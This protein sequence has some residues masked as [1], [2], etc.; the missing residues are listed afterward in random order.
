MSDIRFENLQLPRDAERLMAAPA[1]LADLARTVAAEGR[2]TESGQ[3]DITIGLQGSQLVA[4]VPWLQ[5][6]ARLPMRLGERVL[7]TLRLPGMR[8]TPLAQN[9]LASA[10]AATALLR[11]LHQAYPAHALLVTDAEVETPL[12]QSVAGA[13]SVGYHIV[14]H[15]TDAHLFHRF[16]G[17]YADFFDKRG[18]K[19]RN[20]LRKKEKVFKDAFGEDWTLRE[21]RR[22]DEVEA[23]LQAASALNRKTYQY[24]LFGESIDVD[25]AH[26]SAT[27]RAAA[28]GLFRSFV[29]WA[30]DE[31]LCF[32]LG[33]QRAD[34]VFEH[35]QT[36][37]DPAHRAAS[38]G[39][40]CNIQLLK[41]LYEHDTPTLM[42][43]GS[44]DAEYKR[45]FSTETR[46]TANLVLV[47]RLM[48][49]AWVVGAHRA[50]TA[51]NEHAA[52]LL[53]RLGVKQWLKRRMRGVEAH[54]P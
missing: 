7:F 44:G 26:V 34:G 38:P 15:D 52:S 16:A 51:L 35:R 21:Y 23:F 32:V 10:D 39:L 50:T 22:A 42:D 18:S 5:Q 17:S 13:R 6:E 28:E 33:H 40:F 48:R 54:T 1:G 27:Q 8:I 31:P 25:A 46:T 41:R 4:L 45:L 11:W 19:Y 2:S 30:R 9:G 47:P 3:F 37:F 36:G 49:Y 20:Q 24:R 29:L 14:R 12:Y 53:E 43:F